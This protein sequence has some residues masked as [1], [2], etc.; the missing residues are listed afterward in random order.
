MDLDRELDTAVSLAM[1]AGLAL[2]DYQHQKIEARYKAGHEIVT[3]AD[4]EADRKIRAGLHAAFPADAVFS[5]EGLD[6]AE[7]L[8][9]ERVWIID[10]LDSTSNF[11]ERG[12]EYCVSIGFSFKGRAALG[13]VYNPARGELFA[14]YPDAGV[15][16]NGV[17]VRVSGADTIGDARTSVSRKEWRRSLEFMG[18]P[19]AVMPIA[20]MAYKLARVAA[21]MEDATFSLKRRKEWGICAG[22]ALIAAAGGRATL[23]DGSEI[24]FNRAQLKQPLG[25][26]AAG[27]RLHHTLLSALRLWADHGEVVCGN[28]RV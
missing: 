2:R 10:P 23:L 20:S 22:T 8:A 7:R 18:L 4:L 14:G 17:H 25:M 3:A 28:E 1:D 26:V 13:V 21:G 16:L 9:S 5:E 11:V 15:T 27:P 19:W 12:D 24:Q 6:S